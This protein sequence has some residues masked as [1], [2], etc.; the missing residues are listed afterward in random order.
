MVKN[1]S[2]S[3][4][5]KIGGPLLALKG[6]V[7]IYV[8]Y[9]YTFSF[10]NQD[11]VVLDCRAAVGWKMLWAPVGTRELLWWRQDVFGGKWDQWR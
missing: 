5:Q 10:V 9:S 3:K 2:C 11:S 4:F 6:C 7:Y 8:F 1:I